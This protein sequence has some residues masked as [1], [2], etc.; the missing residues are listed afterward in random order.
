VL[1]LLAVA[2]A[3][4]AIVWAVNAPRSALI[5]ALVMLGFAVVVVVLLYVPE[6]VKEYFRK[7]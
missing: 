4:I 6:G 5:E 7:P 2:S 1:A 3:I